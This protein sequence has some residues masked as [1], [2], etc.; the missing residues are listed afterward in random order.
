MLKSK[1]GFTLIELMIVIAIV[2]ILLAVSIP[3]I[4]YMMNKQKYGT[5]QNYQKVKGMDDVTSKNT[6]SRSSRFE[7]FSNKQSDR[8]REQANKLNDMADELEKNGN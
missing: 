7:G 1:N 4:D 2:G 6:T 5:W 8:L 3:R